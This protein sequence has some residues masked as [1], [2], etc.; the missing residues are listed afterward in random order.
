MTLLIEPLWIAVLGFTG[1][2]IVTLGLLFLLG[3]RR[4]NDKYD[5][6]LLEEAIRTLPVTENNLWYLIDRITLLPFGTRRTE[7]MKSVGKKYKHIFDKKMI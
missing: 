5:A 4:I 1:I 7:L 3:C 6:M 2:L